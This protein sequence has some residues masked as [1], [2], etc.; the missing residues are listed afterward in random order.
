VAAANPTNGDIF[1]STLRGDVWSVPAQVNLPDTSGDDDL[2]TDIAID[3]SGTLYL[4]WAGN[5]ASNRYHYDIF[6]SQNSGSGW[7]PE[8]RVNQVDAYAN[9]R[10]R[11]AVSGPDNI[12][13]A[14]DKGFSFWDHQIRVV[15]FDGQA[16]GREEV[17][18][19][20][21]LSYCSLCDGIALDREGKPWVVWDGGNLSTT[22]H[23]WSNR[24]RPLEAQRAK[25]GDG[26]L[27]Q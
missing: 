4:V 20:S 16:W 27:R 18:S 12:W 9:Y 11:I 13:I 8:L 23:V 2:D 10:P 26:H 3:S 14:W 19:D 5:S 25:F 24:F 21:T 7:S 15:H 6:L 17:I 1:Y 22:W